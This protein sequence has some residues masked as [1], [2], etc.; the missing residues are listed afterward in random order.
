MGKPEIHEQLEMAASS[1]NGM[2]ALHTGGPTHYTLNCACESHQIC[3]LEF[4]RRYLQWSFVVDGI[5]AMRGN[6]CELFY[7]AKKHS[8][9]AR[10][11]CLLKWQPGAL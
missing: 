9:A 7:C 11:L 5:V 3:I 2:G 1:K 4:Y 10:A 8:S 6:L